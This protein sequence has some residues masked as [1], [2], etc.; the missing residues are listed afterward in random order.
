MIGLQRTFRNLNLIIIKRTLWMKNGYFAGV[1]ISD[2]TKYY[3]FL[4]LRKDF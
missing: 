3:Y 4:H 2:K 1:K